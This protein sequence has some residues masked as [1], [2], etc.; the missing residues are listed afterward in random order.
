MALLLNKKLEELRQQTAD[1]AALELGSGKDLADLNE[2]PFELWRK[3]ADYKMMGLGIPDEYQ[4][5]CGNYLSMAVAGEAFVKYGQN[6]GMLLSWFIHLFIARF[7]ILKFGN[8][9]QRN[10]LLPKFAKGEITASLAISEP[11][12]GSHPKYLKTSARLINDVYELSG[13]KT[14]LTNGSIADFFIVFAI[15]NIENNRKGITGFIIPKDIKGLEIT[16]KINLDFMRPSPHCSIR[17]DNCIISKANIIGPEN[18]AFEKIIKPFREL[19]D[20][21]LM[22]PIAGGLAAQMN[23]LLASKSN[24]L[25]SEFDKQIGH[26]QALIDTLRIMAYEAAAML[27]SNKS[28]SEHLSLLLTFR[29][30]AKKAQQVFK[31]IV[32]KTKITENSFLGSL[33]NDLDQAI[34][35]AGNTADIKKKKLGEG[36]RKSVIYGRK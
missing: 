7:V 27:D 6:F 11:G 14:Y 26:Y 8:N 30:I 28:Y 31:N 18:S 15:T 35:L 20:T 23:I 24:A 13:E 16:K 19:E 29:F 21:L 5:C 33:T 9:K 3:M 2:F 17:L 25:T 36:I 4:G 10:T 34:K 32:S 12:T 22:G 1:F